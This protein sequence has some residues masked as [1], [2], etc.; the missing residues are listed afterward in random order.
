MPV[1][2]GGPVARA[3]GRGGGGRGR[4]V[5]GP[6]AGGVCGRGAH[7]PRVRGFLI[8]SCALPEARAPGRWGDQRAR[9][10]GVWLMGRVPASPCVSPRGGSP[11]L[12]ETVLGDTECFSC[13]F[14]RVVTNDVWD[15]LR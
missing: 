10:K 14:V 8:A 11:S 4:G 15:A 2:A 6:A 1:V 9:R 13:S 12:Q 7:T 3:G 5:R